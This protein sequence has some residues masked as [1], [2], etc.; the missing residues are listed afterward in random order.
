MI[1]RQQNR[2]REEEYDT[3]LLNGGMDSVN[4]PTQLSKWHVVDAKN[5]YITEFWTKA[6][7]GLTLL[8]GAVS[9]NVHTEGII[10]KD[11]WDILVRIAGVNFQKLVWSTW[12]NVST[13]TAIPGVLVSYECSDLTT[14]A[15]LTGSATANSTE[16]MLQ[17]LSGTMTI[18]AYSG[19]I[20]RILSGTGA[21][22]ENFISGNDL[23]DIF[24]ESVWET[25]PDGTSTFDIRESTGH[26]IFSNGTDTCFKYDGNTKTDLPNMI[27]FHTMDVNHNRLWWARRD[28][29]YLYVSNLGTQFFPKDNNFLVNASGDTI[30]GV[31]KNHE[32]M[33]VYKYNSRYRVT[34]YDLDTFSL[35][36]VDE[37]VWCIAQRSIAH[38]NQYT[39]FLGYGGVY[40]PASL[41]SSSLDEGLPISKEINNQILAHS[42]AEL[43][44]S[45]WW[46]YDNRYHL[47]IGNEVFVYDIYQSQIKGYHVWTRYVF[48]DP[49][50]SAIVWNGFAYLGWIQSY[51]QDGTTDNGAIIN[52]EIITGD[53][54]QKQ[55]RRYKIYHRSILTTSGTD[56]MVSIYVSVDQTSPAL[57]QTT[58]ANVSE[59]EIRYMVNKRG[60]KIRR[61]YTFPGTNSPEIFSDET[62]FEPLIMNI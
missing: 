47:S 30:S 54:V 19:K 18:N 15:V 55:R 41:D 20:V 59:G 46:V 3:F 35:E 50:K 16:R 32:Q 42:G 52:C 38:G 13:V 45:V 56:T 25:I 57:V 60:K 5:V 40:A 48:A 22:Q 4:D 51:T 7:S 2:Y 24:V 1:K 61:K 12:T 10:L 8:G 37:R 58:N 44:A 21:G 53:E 31:Q 6:R 36:P 28:K 33:S 27:K 9:S 43:E 11:S 49:I 29:D 14:S 34:G 26:V 62:Y 23:T 39:F 17:V